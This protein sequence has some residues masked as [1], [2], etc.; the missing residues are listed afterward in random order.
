MTMNNNNNNNSSSNSNKEALLASLMGDLSMGIAESP[1]SNLM[2]ESNTDAITSTATTTNTTSLF[3]DDDDDDSQHHHHDPPT[4]A[5]ATTGAPFVPPQSLPQPHQP[6]HQEPYSL[7]TREDPLPFAT[8]DTAPLIHP[9]NYGG[10]NPVP[11][12]NTNTSTSSGVVDTDAL[13]E[14]ASS[15]RS[16]WESGLLSMNSAATS[17]TTTAA[18]AAACSGTNS[19][20]GGGGLFDEIDQEQQQQQ[21]QQRALLEQQRQ[22]QQQQQQLELQQQREQQQ[23]QQARAMVFHN[24]NMVPQQL[25]P[26]PPEIL[27][28]GPVQDRSFPPHNLVPSTSSPPP[29]QQQTAMGQTHPSV[30][31]QQQYPTQKQPPA[32]QTNP[33]Y[34]QQGSSSYAMPGATL[35]YPTT[36]A[37]NN[38]SNIGMMGMIPNQ[39]MNLSASYSPATMTSSAGAAPLNPHIGGMIADVRGPQPT[40]PNQYPGMGSSSFMTGSVSATTPSYHSNQFPPSAPTVGI[41]GSGTTIP[42]GGFQSPQPSFTAGMHNVNPQLGRVPNI[43]RSMMTGSVSSSIMP[44]T[45]TTIQPRAALPPQPI[46]RYGTITVDQPL[47]LSSSMGMPRHGAGGVGGG[48]GGG[49]VSS[50]WGSSPHWSYQITTQIPLP[51]MTQPDQPNQPPPPP[52]QLWFVRRRFRHVVALEDRLREDC[53]GAILPPRYVK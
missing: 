47:L 9:N 32:Q 26:S 41:P 3:P 4:A 50:L 17:T 49:I 45:T 21:Q 44:P 25:Q 39:S 20:G 29:Q 36:A 10:T 2:K 40:M 38:N 16:L 37:A 46:I 51:S 42:P 23:Q 33:P 31:P 8:M 24:N 48:G 52:P 6:N 18:A 34:Y 12:T 15:S 5:A 30:W 11:S 53:P 14:S 13:P 35:N 19:S 28:Y 43:Q 22:K 27:P 1:T 7:T